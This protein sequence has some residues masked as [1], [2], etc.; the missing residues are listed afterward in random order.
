MATT[1][2]VGRCLVNHKLLVMLRLLAEVLMG[3]AVGYG[4]LLWYFMGPRP[5]WHYV[6]TCS[7]AVLA[8]ALLLIS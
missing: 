7:A 2:G 4:Y 5:W 6:L 3:L 1:S 8:L